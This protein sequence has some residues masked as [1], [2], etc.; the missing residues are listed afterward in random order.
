MKAVEP[1][2]SRRLAGSAGQTGRRG[3]REPTAT[4]GQARGQSQPRPTTHGGEA[5]GGRWGTDCAGVLTG[6]ADICHEDPRGGTAPPLL[7][8]EQTKRGNL[9]M[10]LEIWD[11]SRKTF[12]LDLNRDCTLHGLHVSDVGSEKLFTP[13]TPKGVPAN[14]IPEPKKTCSSAKVSGLQRSQEQSIGQVP[15][16]PPAPSPTPASAPTGSPAPAAAAAAAPPPPE[17]PRARLPS[18]PPLSVKKKELQPQQQPLQQLLRPPSVPSTPPLLRAPPHGHALPHPHSHP[19]PSHAHPD[20]R[21]LP[22]SQHHDRRLLGHHHPLHH[23]LQYT[24]LQDI[25][26]RGSPVG[27]SKHHL[28]PSPHHHLGGLPSAAPA[29]PLSMSQPLY[30]ALFLL[31]EPL[32][33]PSGHVRKPCPNCNPR[34]P[35]PPTAL[36]SL[37][38]LP[39]PPTQVSTHTCWLAARWL[40]ACT[41]KRRVVGSYK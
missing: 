36:S 25:S 22:P 12:L 14:E 41:D 38:T 26:H 11:R 6:S 35:Y 8:T 19:H 34:Q 21:L 30:L 39:A 18:P 37:G 29:L 4:A 16:S 3:A 10:Q 31:T 1:R 40:A 32:T 5:G 24:S 33:S 2:W 17:P 9:I 15:F 13:T 28:P 7:A 23:P 20:S 27:L